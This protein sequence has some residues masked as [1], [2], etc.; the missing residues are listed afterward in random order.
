MS[1]LQLTL[2][3]DELNAPAN[4]NDLEKILSLFEAYPKNLK[5]KYNEFG[6]YKY[7][8]NIPNNC[9]YEPDSINIGDYIQSLAAKQY[10]P[11]TQ[12]PVLIDRD[13]IAYYN[14]QN[15][16]LI[17]NAWYWIHDGN[18]RFS[19]KINPLLVA[20]H[21]NNLYTIPKE[22]LNYL[23]QHEPIGCR[24]YTTRN[25]RYRQ[26]QQTAK[27]GKLQSPTLIQYGQKSPEYRE[28]ASYRHFYK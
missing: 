16:D 12:I 14:G 24:D 19:D 15:I 5:H 20:V 4:N 17:A 11:D 27:G 9:G 22:T 28:L 2:I 13:K 25:F 21:L 10:L 7:D 26:I 6:L 8:Y 23:K 1:L 18:I 3:I